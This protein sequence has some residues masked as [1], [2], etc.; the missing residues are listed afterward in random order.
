[1]STSPFTGVSI[2]HIWGE[3]MIGA[4]QTF[5]GVDMQM[6]DFLSGLHSLSDAHL[7][8]PVR[9]VM[10]TPLQST[11]SFPSET[12]GP[13]SVNLQR[14]YTGQQYSFYYRR[15]FE[16]SPLLDHLSLLLLPYP[17]QHST[18]PGKY[19]GLVSHTAVLPIPM[20]HRSVDTAEPAST[21]TPKRDPAAEPE[22]PNRQ[23]SPVLP[24]MGVVICSA[25][26]HKLLPTGTAGAA[27]VASTKPTATPARNENAG[28]NTA[29]SSDGG[30]V[31][32]SDGG[33]AGVPTPSPSGEK[34]TVTPPGS[35][36]TPRA[37]AEA[38]AAVAKKGSKRRSLAG[39]ASSLRVVKATRR[40]QPEAPGPAH[41]VEEYLANTEKGIKAVASIKEGTGEWEKAG[42][43][44]DLCIGAGGLWGIFSK[45]G[46]IA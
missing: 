13:A 19:C 11:F 39:L 31:A 14:V 4:D 24:E 36:I 41:S 32:S 28:K 16:G 20:V 40:G 15:V 6:G 34:N 26:P 42:A 30:G 12:R 1:M 43:S 3:H 9:R 46:G 45:A 22:A 37:S 25:S 7:E 35:D 23:A 33:G 44:L 17:V 38:G 2:M 29:S 21:V 27:A 10:F 8:P 5:G 18:H